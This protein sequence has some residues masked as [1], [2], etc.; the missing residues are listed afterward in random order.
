MSATLNMGPAL[1]DKMLD[2]FKWTMVYIMPVLYF[3]GLEGSCGGSTGK[4]AL[5]LFVTSARKPIFV[6]LLM[7]Y[8]IDM[9]VALILAFACIKWMQPIYAPEGWSVGAII[10]GGVYNCLF[11]MLVIITYFSLSEGV[12]GTSLGKICMGVSV[13]QK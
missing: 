4:M 9:A 5:N 7:S 10:A 8:M 12:T 3:S 13:H 2:V 11:G 1:L 6:Y